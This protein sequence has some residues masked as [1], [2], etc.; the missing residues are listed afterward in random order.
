[1]S[2][3]VLASCSI[4][5]ER[6][7]RGTH[8]SSNTRMRERQ[9]PCLLK[10][11]YRQLSGN[12][13]KM[14]NELVER[15]TALKIVKQGL[16]GYPSAGEARRAPHNLG[17]ARNSGFHGELRYRADH[18]Q[19]NRGGLDANDE[20][21]RRAGASAS[22]ECTLSQSSTPSLAHRRRYPR[23]LEPIVRH[24]GDHFT[25]LVMLVIAPLQ[26]SMWPMSPA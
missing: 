2:A 13:R 16:K 9:I 18:Y 20:V 3:T 25:H 23:S 19:A 26:R 24:H 1:M 21:E 5:S 11:C 6:R 14:L 7:G 12:T 17:V 10:C 4:S 22:N 8:S 15:I